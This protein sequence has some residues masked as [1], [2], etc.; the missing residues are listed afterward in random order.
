[1]KTLVGLLTSPSVLALP[2]W[3]K[4]FRIHTDASKTGAEGVL[5]QIQENGRV[6][7]AMVKD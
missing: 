6:C 2:D 3:N 4:P 1:M 7:L 5:T